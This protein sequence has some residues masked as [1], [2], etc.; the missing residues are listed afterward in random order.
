MVYFTVAV[1]LLSTLLSRTRE[2]ELIEVM[3]KISSQPHCCEVHV[4]DG[5]QTSRTDMAAIRSDA[6]RWRIAGYGIYLYIYFTQLND[7]A[8]HSILVP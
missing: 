6:C 7:V 1:S 8:L 2:I 5:A 4:D 3:E